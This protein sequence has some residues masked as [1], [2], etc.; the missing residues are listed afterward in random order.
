MERRFCGISGQ[1]RCSWLT[2]SLTLEVW[3]LKFVCLGWPLMFHRS[4]S[5]PSKVH[6]SHKTNP[7]PV[8][9][10]THIF[11][12]SNDNMSFKFL[13]SFGLGRKPRFPRA[14]KVCTRQVNELEG[15]TVVPCGHCNWHADC[16][17]EFS[18]ARRI[19]EK[20]MVCPECDGPVQW[21]KWPREPK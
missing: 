5:I 16:W 7:L 11:I 15:P 12:S 18:V 2:F 21:E 8:P 1:N 3:S 6:A 20:V 4:Q 14:C 10:L 17:F 13:R 19:Y 9:L